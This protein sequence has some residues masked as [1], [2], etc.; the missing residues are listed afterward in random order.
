MKT[1]S[2]EKRTSRGKASRPAG[3]RLASKAE[4][5]AAR[6]GCRAWLVF[7]HGRLSIEP[8]D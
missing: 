3:K 7:D 6:K 2:I 1:G 4:R 8:I 5:Y